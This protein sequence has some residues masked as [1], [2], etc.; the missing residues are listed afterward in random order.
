[1]PA[2]RWRPRLV[3]RKLGDAGNTK[4]IFAGVVGECI[5][6]PGVVCPL[7]SRSVDQAPIRDVPERRETIN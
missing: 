4:A 7:F 6:R 5:T 1:M 2:R 3:R